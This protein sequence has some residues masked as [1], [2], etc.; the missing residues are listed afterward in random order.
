MSTDS[1]PLSF[2]DGSCI[3]HFLSRNINKVLTDFGEASLLGIKAISDGQIAP[4]NPNE[5]SRSQVY[6]HNNIFFSR[7]ID[8]GIETFKVAKGD[9]A[10]RKSAS[11]D[12]Q[13]L[14]AL[15]RMEK[16]GLYTLATVLVDYLGT[17]FVC[18]SIL[19]GILS[20]EKSH[21]LLYG[22][23]EASLPLTWDEDMHKILD[24]TL[25]KFWIA[26][27]PL[28]RKPLT[29]ERLTATGSTTEGK[30]S[31]GG[32][33]PTIDMCGPIEAKGIRGSDQRKY[34]LDMTRLT[35]RDANWVEE[36]KGGTGK[37][38]SLLTK[39]VS[40]KHVPKS[41]DDDEWTLS[42][43]R[44]ELVNSYAQMKIAKY[45]N[46]KKQKD[47]E[48]KKESEASVAT[49][50]DGKDKEDSKKEE[51][52][53]SLS[54]EDMEYVKSL[55]LNV[56]V[57]LPDI[58][59]LEGID[60]TAFNQQK[61]DE[62]MARDI[63]KFL[64]D[65]ILPGLTYEI[66]VNTRGQM[67]HD[68]KSLTDFI[69][70]N[71]INCRYLGRLA[72]LAQAE[73]E[74]DRK[75]MNLYKQGKSKE[76]SRK[77]MPPF[78][79]ELL[80]C[81]MVA[82]AAKHVL[83]RYLTENGGM[84]ALY[85]MQTVSSFL[86][87]LVSSAEET[88]GQTENR[89][90]KRDANE[91][92]E[93]DFAALTLYDVGGDGDAA[94]GSIRSRSQVWN[95]IEKEIGRR[96]RYSLTL[97]NRPGQ[98]SRA[99]YIPLL[100][101]V[102]QRTGVRLA[103]KSYDIGGKCVCNG[104]G[105]LSPSYPISPLDIIDI[106]PSMKH[107]AAYEGGFICCSSESIS[108]LPPLHIS[109]P[110]ARSTLESAHLLHKRKQLA[111][112]LDL[113]Q[114]AA[115]LYQRVAETSAH[116]GVV[117]C[118][119]LMGTILLDAGE[120]ALAAGNYARALSLMVQIKGFD[121]SDAI[122]FHLVISQALLAGGKISKAIKHLRAAI[123]LIEM[124]SGPNHTELASLYHKL[125]SVYHGA[126]DMETALRLYQEAAS[127]VSSDRLME[128]MISKSLAVAY[129]TAGDFKAALDAEKVAYRYF[130]MTLGNDHKLTKASDEALAHFTMA[131]VRQ[132]SKKVKDL[133]SQEQEAVADAI[134]SELEAE[135]AAAAQ[136]KKKK[137]N[138][139][140][141]GKR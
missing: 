131:A 127:R 107:A 69:H 55:R 91:P 29:V 67:P 122:N 125:G 20:G 71:G 113:A 138:K 120:T 83:N 95:D 78:W 56:N 98:D 140:K 109:L 87:S 44:A 103:A 94:P 18:Q 2:F 114:E 130:A 19:P 49:Q 9:Q 76:L 81:E 14:G 80:E 8:A 6:L 4:M 70:Q 52:Q 22:T 126:D 47:E 116:P 108:G 31:D 48:Q 51:S 34:V 38:E 13:C 101:R 25:G 68:G 139:K 37:W 135:E 28:P 35:P 96:F 86:S 118:I 85:P 23:V 88:A 128:G 63:A 45:M 110:D 46:E 72:T 53:S 61:E 104:G 90:S 105:Q 16:R 92:D 97:F 73:E 99:L 58:K 60:T 7:A 65:Q 43:L 117:S 1:T 36:E 75:E 136:A 84:V 137:K 115:S 11:R 50:D 33:S 66:R 24:E 32:E 27:R 10:A 133:K 134:A 132:G 112:A 5:P 141:K 111:Q 129:A 40:N 54:D 124:S 121:S 74:R 123:F 100:R 82:R 77:A 42:V 17:R 93:E 57:F 3:L 39:A 102:C 89:M 59:S 30:K 26:N 21:T 64:W 119:E 41:L 106:V 62:E 12:M 79:L 15:H